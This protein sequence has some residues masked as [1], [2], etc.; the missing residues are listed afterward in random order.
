M[1]PFFDYRH[2]VGLEET[3]LVGNVYFSHFVRW[4]GR[5][6]ESFLRQRAPE[7]LAALGDGLKIFTLSCSCE[8]LAEVTAFDEISVRLTLDD[9][10]QSQIAFSFD[11]LRM[12]EEKAVAVGRQR[13]VCMR[14]QD[15]SMIPARVPDSLRAALAPFGR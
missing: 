2:I 1:K 5:C 4:Q 6:R 10:T 11:Y 9:V 14:E 15:G 7:V 8:Y 3:N 12:P 13:V